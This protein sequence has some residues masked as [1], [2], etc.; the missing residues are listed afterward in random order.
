MDTAPLH[1]EFLAA[2]QNLAMQLLV[3]HGSYTCMVFSNDVFIEAESIIE[4]LDTN[5]GDYDMVCSLDLSY[6]WVVRNRLGHL[7]ST[8]WPYF[9]EDTGFHVVMADAPAPMF[10]CWNG[11][12]ALHADPF[13]LPTLH[14]GQLSPCCSRTPLCRLC[15][16][17]HLCPARA[18]AVST[19][20]SYCCKGVHVKPHV[21]FGYVWE[22]YVSFK[23]ITWHWAVKWWIEQVENGNG[24]HLAKMVLREPAPVWQWDSGEYHPVCVYIVYSLH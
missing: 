13:L 5:G 1:I 23:Y 10:T 11:I 4:L 3:E 22:Y 12:V 18:L 7:A 8:L 17:A 6:W 15:A 24:V 9:L 21:I 14:T 20:P 16:S 19:S 2:L